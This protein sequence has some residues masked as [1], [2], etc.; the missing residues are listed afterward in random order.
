[1]S[2]DQEERD[3]ANQ[4]R[5]KQA[6]LSAGPPPSTPTGSRPYEYQSSVTPSPVPSSLGNFVTLTKANKAPPSQAGSEEGFLV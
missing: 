1:M 5:R 6:Q 2:E 3:Y 4:L